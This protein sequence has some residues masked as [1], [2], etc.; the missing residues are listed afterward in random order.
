MRRPEDPTVLRKQSLRASKKRRFLAA[1]V[2]SLL[3]SEYSA[4]TPLLGRNP[5]VNAGAT[6]H[7]NLYA[8][9]GLTLTLP[10]TG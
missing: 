7:V 8:F 1:A 9:L 2:S 6:F 5:R 4:P 10:L 3:L